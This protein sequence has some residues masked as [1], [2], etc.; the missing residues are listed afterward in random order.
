MGKLKWNVE[1]IKTECENLGIELLSNE[2]IQK[3]KQIFKCNCGNSFERKF[4]NV[5]LGQIFCNNCREKIDKENKLMELKK[6]F[7][8]FEYEVY[9]GN[10]GCE[11]LDDYT[12]YKSNKSK[13]KMKCKCGNIFFPTA[14]NFK[15]G[16]TQCK[17]CGDMESGNKKRLKKDFMFDY[18]ESVGYKPISHKFYEK[19]NILLVSCQNENHEPY[20]VNFINFYHGK[21]RCPIC[22]LSKG[23]EKV[24]EVLTNHSIQFKREYSIDSLKGIN[25]RKLRFDFYIE[26]NNEQIVIEYDGE[27]HFKP[28]FGEYEFD[29]TK[30]N[31]AIKNEYCS[32]NNIRLLRIPYNKFNNIEEII[33]EFL[34][35][36]NTEITNRSKKILVS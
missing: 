27:Q 18:V 6:N 3:E 34:N 35:I 4:S 24:K 14:N 2:Y 23:E 26:F 22:N 12:V 20:E 10:S 36:G 19:K 5:L 11:I 31:D 13:I 33:E 29:R 9:Q 30:R 21:T 28:K 16:A 7:E 15:K 32:K 1:K 17:V 25:G 8:K